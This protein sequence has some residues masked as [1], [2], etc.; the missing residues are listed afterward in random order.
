MNPLVLGLG[1]VSAMAGWLGFYAM[2][3]E[4]A[5]I[6]RGICVFFGVLAVCAM[7]APSHRK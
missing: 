2:N 7:L 6:A 1:G 5:W 3:G 4:A